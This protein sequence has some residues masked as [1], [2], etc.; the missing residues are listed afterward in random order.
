[1]S[2]LKTT[3][4]TLRVQGRK[5]LIPYVTAGFPFADITP[6][7]LHGM[8]AAGADVIELG[9]PFSDPMADGPVIQK[10]GERA[11]ALGIGTAQVLAI[12]REF[13]QRDDST[14]IV[15]MGYANPVERYDQRHSTD[16]SSGSFARDAAVAGVDGVLIVDYPPEECADFAATLRSQ[17]LDLIF[18]LAPTSTEER[19]ASVARLASGYVYYVSLKGVTGAGHLDTDAVAEALPRIRR[20]VGALPVG[21]GFGIRD[22]DTARAIGRTADAVVIGSRLIQLIEDQPRETVVA[23]AAGFLRGIRAALDADAP[24]ASSAYGA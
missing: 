16:G 14:P 19:I 5:A 23:T 20:H 22:A 2:R 9:V 1:M 11:L 13:R 15:L 24:A 4:D 8:V 12:V 6:A 7:L 18:L 10:A 17:G 3:F 21:V